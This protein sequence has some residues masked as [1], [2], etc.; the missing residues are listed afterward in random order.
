MTKRGALKKIINK[1]F[2]QF[3]TINME[4]KACK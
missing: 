1:D 4:F 3:K 2:Q